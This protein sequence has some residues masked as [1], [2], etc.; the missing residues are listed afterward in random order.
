[1][2]RETFALA[3][4]VRRPD[5]VQRHFVGQPRYRHHL[6][7]HRVSCSCGWSTTST[8]ARCWAAA[9]RHFVRDEVRR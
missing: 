8:Y 3:V 6:L 1:M 9:E 4:P 2:R 7:A 5:T